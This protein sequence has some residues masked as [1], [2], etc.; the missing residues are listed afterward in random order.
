[1][2]EALEQEKQI[3]IYLVTTPL[4]AIGSKSSHVIEKL[5]QQPFD[6]GCYVKAQCGRSINYEIIRGYD[7]RSN[8][9]VIFQCTKS[10]RPVLISRDVHRFANMLNRCMVC[11]YSDGGQ[12]VHNPEY[13]SFRFLVAKKKRK[14]RALATSTTV[15]CVE[16]SDVEHFVLAQPHEKVR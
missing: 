6:Q 4:V 16:G 14:R 7:H 5:D 12:P 3:R 13:D 15:I 11:G 10:R 8:S 2:Q 9:L 1:M